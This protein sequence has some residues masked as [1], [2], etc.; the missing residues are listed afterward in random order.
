MNVLKSQNHKIISSDRRTNEL[1]SPT[2]SRTISK[3][4]NIE[5]GISLHRHSIWGYLPTPMPWKK[6][7]PQEQS[8]KTCPNTWHWKSEKYEQRK[9]R[10]WSYSKTDKVLNAKGST[11]QKTARGQAYKQVNDRRTTPCNLLGVQEII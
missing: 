6:K 1:E 9:W 8:L 2:C 4:T 3:A 11:N 10:G 5:D 7:R